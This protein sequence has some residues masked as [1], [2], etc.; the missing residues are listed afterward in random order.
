V[1]GDLR[2]VLAVAVTAEILSSVL[3][4]VHQTRLLLCARCRVIVR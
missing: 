4:V 1:S 2:G 3:A